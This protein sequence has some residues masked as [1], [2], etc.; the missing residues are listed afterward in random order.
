SL[1]KGKEPG[2][3]HTGIEFVW[4]EKR[5]YFQPEQIRHGSL[6]DYLAASPAEGDFFPAVT[7]AFLL[8]RKGDWKGSAAF[9][10]IMIMVWR[11]LIFVCVWGGI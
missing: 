10:W 11:I 2:V 8:C 4:N 1:P 7:G 5:G 6:K 3:H 9:L